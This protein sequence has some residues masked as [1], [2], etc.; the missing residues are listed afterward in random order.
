M[1]EHQ[2]VLVHSLHADLHSF[3]IKEKER[4]ANVEKLK[5]SPRHTVMTF[6]LNSQ[7]HFHSKY[8]L[9]ER[10]RITVIARAW[11]SRYFTAI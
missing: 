10:H 7:H 5:R 6:Q 3:R 2:H 1:H 11:Y 8:N 9:S 4:Q